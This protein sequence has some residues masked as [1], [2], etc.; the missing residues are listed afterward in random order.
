[1]AAIIFN[2]LEEAC[3]YVQGIAKLTDTTNIAATVFHDF[4]WH[5]R[6]C[7]EVSLRQTTSP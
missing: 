5:C 1:M 4:D 7:R 3:A 6:E 2:K